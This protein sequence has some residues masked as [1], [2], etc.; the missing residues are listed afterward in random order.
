MAIF[1]EYPRIHYNLTRANAYVTAGYGKFCKI[2]AVFLQIN[3]FSNC[4][5]PFKQQGFL[6]SI[7]FIC[8]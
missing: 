7:A 2:N 3:R 8:K 1:F 5:Q 6:A 4:T